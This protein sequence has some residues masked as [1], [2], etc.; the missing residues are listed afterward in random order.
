LGRG[1]VFLHRYLRELDFEL[2]AVRSVDH[3]ITMSRED[4]ARLRR[5]APDLPISVSPCGVDCR[6][7]CP[8]ETVPEVDLLFVGHFGHP[9]NV[10]AATLL[11]R[12]IVPRLG[13]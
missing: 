5:F 3:V 12:E 11:V 1:L 9:P 4:A 7:F 10:D 6:T 8:R 13:R 2:R